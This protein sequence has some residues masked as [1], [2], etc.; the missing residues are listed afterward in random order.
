MV[1]T[2]FLCSS[3]FIADVVLVLPM[4]VLLQLSYM[5]PCIHT[6][7]CGSSPRNRLNADPN[8]NESL[9]HSPHLSPGVSV[10]YGSFPERNGYGNDI[11]HIVN[12]G[13]TGVS[14]G[15]V[16]VR[17]FSVFSIFFSVALPY[18]FNMAFQSIYFML[19]VTL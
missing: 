12:I 9:L 3:C 7:S 10:E 14:W 15:G 13:S 16:V 4:Q 6:L 1:S 18:L 2:S 19:T 8:L 5:V 17:F 11:V